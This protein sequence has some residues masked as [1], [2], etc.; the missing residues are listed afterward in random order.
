M[1]GL[2]MDSLLAKLA[3]NEDVKKVM[4]QVTSV[5]NGV[6][7]AMTH[8]NNR[9]DKIEQ[10]HTSDSVKLD[11]IVYLLENPC[12]IVAAADDGLMQLLAEGGEE[13]EMVE[14]E[15]M[16]PSQPDG[17][18]VLSVTEINSYKN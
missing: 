16:P 4:A 11:R 18:P 12:N 7:L 1:L 6:I 8:F 5:C 14:I 13:M 2:D 10:M 9:F 15:P 3:E 17:R